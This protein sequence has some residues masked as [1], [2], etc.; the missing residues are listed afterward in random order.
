MRSMPP[1][2]ALLAA[3]ALSVGAFAL[4]RFTAAPDLCLVDSAE[5][6]LAATTGGVPHPPGFPLFRL[7]GGLF[8]AMPFADPIR[9]LNLMSA[10]FVAL[11]CGAVV[12]SAERMLAIAGGAG[13][14]ATDE[15]HRTAAAFVAGVAFATAWNP[16]V[17]SGVTEVYALNVFLTAAAWACAWCGVAAL[18]LAR[19]EEVPPVAWRWITAA[20]LLA[21]LTLANHH[22]TG[23]LAFPVLLGMLAWTRPALFRT[24]RFWITSVACVVASLSLYLTLFPAARRDVALDWGGIDSWR[25]L[26]RHVAGQQYALQMGSTGD[27]AMRVA[28]VFFRTLFH[29]VGIAPALLVLVALVAAARLPRP[30]GG[31]ARDEARRAALAWLAPLLLIALNLALSSMYVAGP[32]DR[33]AYDLPATVAWCLL[34]GVGAWALL[35]AARLPVVPS[36]L[37]AAAA[38]GIVVTLDIRDHFDACDL[39]DEHTAR[40][41]V[42]EALRDV[43][44]GGVVITAEWNLYAPY[45]YMRHVEGF[46]TDVHVIDVLMMRRFWYMDYLERTYPDLLAASRDAFDPLREQITRFD[47]GESYDATHIQQL[48]DA[49][50]RKWIEV[51]ISSGGGSFLEGSVTDHPQERSWIAAT[52]SVPAGLLIRCL[53]GTDPV[54]VP[55]LAPYDAGNLAYLRSRI[56]TRA[57]ERDV[58]DLPERHHPY[59]R[60]WRAYQSAVE[61]SLLVGARTGR[62]EF[63][64]RVS[65]YGQWFPE[66]ERSAVHALGMGGG[67]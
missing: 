1:R 54:E 8:A 57:V 6:A 67:E 49:A 22:A 32:E 36:L 35:R 18:P 43:G 23:V 42:E 2:S 53:G 59:Y 38:A 41:F 28:G 13:T 14:A 50:I 46:R 60:V 61:A 15:A 62:E 45:L 29:G 27:E 39:R 26:L 19:R 47:L 20:S 3:A 25:F 66:V 63:E 24:R 10:F 7:V 51:G 21:S 11:T 34:A 5:L 17:W 64:A 44:E 58:S 30:K 52:P 65:A 48:Y 4:Y 12:L 16:W 33:M 56:T 31:R 55:P 40:R 37:A 9:M